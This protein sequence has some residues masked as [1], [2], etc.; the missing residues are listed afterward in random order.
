MFTIINSS[1]M[2]QK[3]IKNKSHRISLLRRLVFRVLVHTKY[4]LSDKSYL[5]ILYWVK[6]GKFLHLKHPKTFS[7]K[8]Q[9]LKLYDRRP[10]YTIM[11]DK[12]K[13]KEYVA[14]ILGEEYIIPTLGVWDDPDKIDFDAL[15]DRFV[16]KCNHNS[17]LGMYICKDKSKMDVEKVK[18]DLRKGLA[19]DYFI[20]NREWPYKNV[21]RRILAEKFIDPVSGMNDLPDYKFFCFDGEVKALFIATDRQ[22]PNEEVKFDFFDA[23]FNHLPFRQGH[24]NAKVTPQKPKNFELMKKAAAQLSQGIPQVRIDF[25]EV[26]DKVLF[27][28]LTFFHFS[29]IM[30][31]RPEE[32]DE[33][34]G[35]M[36]NLPGDKRWRVC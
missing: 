33:R 5:R 23:D 9:W 16:L 8:L 6:M 13:A 35:E 10:E 4:Y 3:E 30:P 36:L 14:S 22:N 12:V 34:F 15:P 27:G 17:G 24:E 20:D 28:E 7:E 1:K 32:W 11:V 26:G 21:P 19:Q 29:G 25:Y 31:F 2:T 18:Q